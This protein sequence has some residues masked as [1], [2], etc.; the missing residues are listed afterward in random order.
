[1]FLQGEIV[2][3][4]LWSESIYN[5]L[6]VFTL[7]NLLDI[8][9]TYNVVKKTST[10]SEANPIARFIMQRMGLTGLFILKYLGMGLIVLIGFITNA[11]ETSI[12][13]NNIILSGV[14][15][16]NSYINLKEH[17]EEKSKTKK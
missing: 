14:V 2:N 15:A 16:W 5:S 11:L 12:W 8:I 7:L 1:M 10:E 4:G 13:I 9:T 6:L 3:E 17:V